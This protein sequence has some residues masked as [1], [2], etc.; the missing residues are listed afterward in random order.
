MSCDV[1]HLSEGRVGKII[2]KWVDRVK[3]DHMSA[4]L[5]VQGACPRLHAL[6]Q[7]CNLRV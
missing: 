5:K 7:C 6:T 1:K 3:G 4:G 2:P